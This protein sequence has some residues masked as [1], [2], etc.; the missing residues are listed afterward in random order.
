MIKRLFD[1]VVSFCGLLASSPILLLAA[2]AV[3][4]DSAGPVL[5]KQ[6][7]IGRHFVPFQILKFRS[8]TVRSEGPQITA[9]G[10]ARVTRAGRILRRTKFDELPQ[11]LNV[12]RGDMSLVGPRPEVRKYVEQFR[13]DYAEILRVR[14]GVTDL[15][16]IHYRDEE[17]I[18]AAA[19]DSEREYVERVLP[20]K[21]DLAK[22]YI[23]RAS[24]RLDFEILVRTFFSVIGDA[25]QSPDSA[26]GGQH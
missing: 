19:P 3:K 11:L 10:D 21:I 23:R 18:L 12:L 16:S 24:L 26:R 7:R 5:F 25:P 15:A 17:R 2:I 6:E 8:M 1:I 22:E 20:H 9:A 14:P 4:L 13:S